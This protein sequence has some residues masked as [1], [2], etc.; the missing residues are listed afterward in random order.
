LIPAFS[1]GRTQELIFAMD[2]LH[3]FE[4][5]PEIPI[6]VD[7]PLA[8]KGT[9]IFKNHLSAF[10]ERFQRYLSFDASPFSFPNLH[11]PK[12]VD[13]SKAIH[14]I[15]DG[16]VVVSASGM[17]DAG[18]IRHHLF[19]HL[20]NPKNAV[21][22]VGYAEPSTLGGQLISG[23]A[24][25]RLFGED[26]PVR[27]KIVRAGSFSG[28]ADWEEMLDYLCLQKPEKLKTVFLVHG[29][30]HVQKNWANRLQEHGF[31]KVLIPDL[32]QEF[33]IG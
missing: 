32:Q 7:S 16:A 3:N 26:I 18:R 6:F 33:E 11:F 17:M 2:Y 19:N 24:S 22:V 25:V 1:I 5:L 28:H 27:A 30:E 23:A 4:S 14:Q 29:E 10:N 9:E 21:L 13:E 12:T 31:S 20:S 15:R 8:T